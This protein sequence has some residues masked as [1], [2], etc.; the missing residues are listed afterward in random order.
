MICTLVASWLIFWLHLC[1][2]SKIMTACSVGR[3]GCRKVGQAKIYTCTSELIQIIARERASTNG[4]VSLSVWHKKYVHLMSQSRSEIFQ[5]W[6]CLWQD[7]CWPS[8]CLCLSLY[9]CFAYLWYLPM[10]TKN[11]CIGNHVL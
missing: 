6:L 10:P 1:F 5:S 9:W 2:C 7:G 8:P 4:V 11:D 3:R